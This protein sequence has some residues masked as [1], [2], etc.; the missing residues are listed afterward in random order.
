MGAGQDKKDILALQQ[1]ILDVNVNQK[2][3]VVLELAEKITV[4]PSISH[5][6]VRKSKKQGWK[7]EEVADIIY[8]T[9]YFNLMT[10][11]VTAF[12]VPPDKTHPFKVDEKLPM[13]S[14]SG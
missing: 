2:E 13:I 12:D 14:C 1:N 6:L 8:F 7:N 3:K 9:S 4:N 10:R 11:V 5:K